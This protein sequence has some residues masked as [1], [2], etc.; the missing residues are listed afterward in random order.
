MTDLDG[1][2]VHGLG[3]ESFELT[4]FYGKSQRNFSMTTVNGMGGNRTAE[5]QVQQ[6]MRSDVIIDRIRIEILNSAQTNA[7]TFA[8]RKNGVDLSVPE[9]FPA[10]ATAD[11]TLAES[12]EASKD[13][14]VNWQF[15]GGDG[16]NILDSR[17]S[18]RM[19]FKP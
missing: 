14:L 3:G 4:I 1:K 17:I 11:K 18:F 15:R 2:N 10:L 16:A 8:L 5:S 7:I 6:A 13:D 19:R 9:V 12:Y